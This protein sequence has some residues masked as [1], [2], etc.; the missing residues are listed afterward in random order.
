MTVRTD[1]RPETEGPAND[2]FRLRAAVEVETILKDIVARR[3][4]VTLYYGADRF[5]VSTLLAA[6]ARSGVTLDAARDDATTRAIATSPTVTA[7]TFV[8]QIKTQFTLRQL[9]AAAHTGKPAISAP[10]PDSILRLQRRESFRVAPP[11]SAGLTISV[12]LPGRAPVSF[13]LGDLSVGGVAVL[14][15][16]PIRE[17]VPGAVFDDCSLTLPEHGTIKVALQIRNQR[18]AGADN[19]LRYGCRFHNLAGTVAS[20]IQRSINDLQKLARATAR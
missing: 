11:R 15:G 3:L 1:I 19:G 17:F 13:S 2:E 6:D 4:L 12:P 16:P 14:T 20:L 18:P 7:I 9:R 5:I 8:D 10:L